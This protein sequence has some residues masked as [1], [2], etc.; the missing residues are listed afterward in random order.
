VTASG[1]EL[2]SRRISPVWRWT[3]IVTVVFLALVGAATV[4]RICDF[5]RRWAR[6][7]AHRVL[8]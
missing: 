6:D 1:S 8:D 7:H 3:L 2:T 4:R 5:P